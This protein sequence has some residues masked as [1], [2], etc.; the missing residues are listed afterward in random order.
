M[1]MIAKLVI[2]LFNISNLLLIRC[3]LVNIPIF[4]EETI[5]GQ[6]SSYTIEMEREIY[7][8]R[9]IGKKEFDEGTKEI[10][11][12]GYFTIANKMKCAFSDTREILLNLTI[13]VKM[14]LRPNIAFVI[15]NE[16]IN[17]S[18]SFTR[19]DSMYCEIYYATNK[20]QSFYTVY[21]KNFNI[22]GQT[23]IKSHNSQRFVEIEVFSEIPHFVVLKLTVFIE[24]RGNKNEMQIITFKEYLTPLYVK[25]AYKNLTKQLVEHINFYSLVSNMD[26]I[27]SNK[28]KSGI[29][30]T[31]LKNLESL[32]KFEDDI[33]IY[34]NKSIIIKNAVTLSYSTKFFM[35]D[36]K[37]KIILRENP[38]CSELKLNSCMG[39]CIDYSPDCQFLEPKD[40]IMNGS[41]AKNDQNIIEVERTF[42]NR[43]LIGV[44]RS[45]DNRTNIEVDKT[46][47]NT[48]IIKVESTFDNRTIIEFKNSESKYMIIIILALIFNI[49]CLLYFYMKIRNLQHISERMN[50]NSTE[51]F[52]L[53][54]K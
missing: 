28:H 53:N 11:F 2:Y 25:T 45:F 41:N 43:T 24:V 35:I 15:D 14:E 54:E 34:L 49:A 23:E 47:D 17:L 16:S 20:A 21:V 42:D 52:K 27:C 40:T 5:Y 48:K 22:I 13:G 38:N 4:N 44:E 46:S 29:I 12:H 26:I 7:H 36:L 51:L 10:L 18:G 32:D 19:E 8:F 33:F 31:S 6:L 1:L 3:Y 30:R 37:F 39:Y 9:N 50:K